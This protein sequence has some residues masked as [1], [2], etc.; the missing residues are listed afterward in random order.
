[1]N[2]KKEQELFN[3]DEELIKYRMEITKLNERIQKKNLERGTLIMDLV[4][5]KGKLLKR[6]LEII[7]ND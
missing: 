1:M 2:E 6:K 7:E 5:I 3:R 4:K